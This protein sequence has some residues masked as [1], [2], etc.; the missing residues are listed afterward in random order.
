[1]YSANGFG[2]FD[3]AGNVWEFTADAWTGYSNGLESATH[4]NLS[5]SGNEYLDVTSRR[6]IRGGSWGGSPV[7]LWVEYRD[8]HPPNG[9]RDLVGFRCAESARDK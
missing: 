5:T 4:V 3:M 2:I 6:V 9:A 8:S 7:N 1:M